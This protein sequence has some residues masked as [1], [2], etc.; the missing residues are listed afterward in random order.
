MKFS[1]V[2]IVLIG[3]IGLFIAAC[4]STSDETACQPTSSPFATPY[5]NDLDDVRVAYAPNIPISRVYTFS[6]QVKRGQL[7]K[8]HIN[9]GLIFCLRPTSSWHGNDGWDIVISDSM[10]DD[11]GQGLN[12]I[13]TPPF[14]GMNPIYIEG[15]HFRNDKNTAENDGSVNAP[16][17]VRAF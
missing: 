3:I 5:I 13:V 11:C 4:K 17:E 1:C 12:G 15:W 6:G 8:N 9:D 16:Q 7:Y 10:D 14:H 2:T